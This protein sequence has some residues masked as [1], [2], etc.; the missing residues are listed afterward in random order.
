MATATLVLCVSSLRN[1]LACSCFHKLLKDCMS[2]LVVGGHNMIPTVLLD[3]H[4]MVKVCD[5]FFHYWCSMCSLLHTCWADMWSK[6]A[7]IIFKAAIH[8]FHVKIQ[9]FVS[10]ESSM[11]IA[12]AVPL[13]VMC[14]L[15][16]KC[17]ADVAQ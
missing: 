7:D 10:T 17:N 1:I 13:Q 11:W 6:S 4:V 8:M 12:S 15:F 2:V 16:T 14:L 3:V 9:R 5:A